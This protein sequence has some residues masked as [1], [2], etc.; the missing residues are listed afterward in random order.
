MSSTTEDP[1]MSQPVGPGSGGQTIFLP[2]C[3]WILVAIYSLL[4]NVI[5]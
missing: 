1:P 4:S 3:A 2:H 5:F